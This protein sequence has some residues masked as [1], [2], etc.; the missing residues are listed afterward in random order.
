ML[1]ITP[2]TS[3][4]MFPAN[5]R[6]FLLAPAAP[7]IPAAQQTLQPGQIFQIAQP[8]WPFDNVMPSF[9]AL[10]ATTIFA[11]FFLVAF[12]ELGALINYFF[13]SKLGVAGHPVLGM[14]LSLLAFTMLLIT[15]ENDIKKRSGY[16]SEGSDPRWVVA[17]SLVASLCAVL[18]A[19]STFQTP[20]AAPEEEN[21]AKA[22]KMDE[23][24][25]SR[26]QLKKQAKREAKKHTAKSD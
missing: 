21:A 6:E 19:S 11:A 26:R 4:P 14:T 2:P 12:K 1:E 7:A 17:F 10:F 23:P 5:F 24:R 25:G 20:V 9:Y 3:I 15:Y 22:D 8:R 18:W 16:Y 13:H